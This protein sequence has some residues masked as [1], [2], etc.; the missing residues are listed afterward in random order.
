MIFAYGSFEYLSIHDTIFFKSLNLN[1]IDLGLQ[2]QNF[3][4]GAG[5]NFF[6][7]QELKF[8]TDLKQ[9]EQLI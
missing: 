9:S 4:H 3:V 5:G 7:Y 6:R 2:L 8:L 1:P